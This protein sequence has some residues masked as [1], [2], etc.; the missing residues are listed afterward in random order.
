MAKELNRG[1]ETEKLKFYSGSPRE[2][3]ALIAAATHRVWSLSEENKS[4]PEYLTKP[5]FG[6]EALYKNNIKIHIETGH[7]YVDNQT[8]GE[9]SV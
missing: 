1:R 4:F 5:P 7:I 6:P 8:G 9:R 3:S 2:A